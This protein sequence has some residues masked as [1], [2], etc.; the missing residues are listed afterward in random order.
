M[1]EQ[2]PEE[3]HVPQEI[4]EQL[5]D[6]EMIKRQVIDGRTFQEILGYSETVMED[7]Y[8]KA[9]SLYERQ[10]Y[11]K[12]ADVFVFLTTLNPYIHNYW[13]G[14]GMSEQLNENYQNALLAYAMGMLTQIQ[15][16]VIYYHSGNCYRALGDSVNAL[17]SYELAA[18]YAIDHPEYEAIKERALEEW[19]RLREE[20]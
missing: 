6:V 11:Q 5:R 9:R 20:I 12:A 4:L 7:F 14:L 19:R 13:L 15:N 16:P 10:E 1:S 17:Q 18:K 2:E 3:F 8:A